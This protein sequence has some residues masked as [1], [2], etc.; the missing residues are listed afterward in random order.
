V[1]EGQE[2]PRLGME[3]KVDGGDGWR[4]PM[5]WEG[6]ATVREEP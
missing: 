5:R 2:A 3:E 6:A 4:R 1:V